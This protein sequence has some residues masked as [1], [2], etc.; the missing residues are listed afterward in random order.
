[1]KPPYTCR[2]CGAPSWYEP[3][4]Q[5]CPPDYCHE[6]DHGEAPH[7]EPDNYYNEEGE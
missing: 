4:D 5:L 3:I 7:G 6:G 2:F 1:M